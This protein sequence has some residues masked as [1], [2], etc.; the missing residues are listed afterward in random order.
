[1]SRLVVSLIINGFLVYIGA[2]LL[3]GVAVDGYLSAIIAGAVLGLLNWLV[4]PVLTFLTLPITI[5][6]HG[7]FL[8]V[9]NGLMVMAAGALLDGFAVSGL[10]PA[11]IFSIV[12]T[13]GNW[14]LQGSKSSKK[15]K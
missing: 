2:Y 4:K 14:L 9:I 3:D 1:M 11:I 15:A 5:L 12:L 6:K 13:I 10:I 8:L 7:M